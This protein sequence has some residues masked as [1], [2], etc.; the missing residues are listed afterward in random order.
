MTE[1]LLTRAEAADACR[2]TTKTILR[3]V[4]AG[5]LHELRTPGFHARYREA[6]VAALLTNQEADHA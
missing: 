1:R 4:R 6:D 2:V 5:K 3:W